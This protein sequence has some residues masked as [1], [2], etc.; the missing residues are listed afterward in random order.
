MFALIDI[1]KYLT[2]IS[3]FGIFISC[4]SGFIEINNNFDSCRLLVSCIVFIHIGA[5]L[6]VEYINKNKDEMKI[7]HFA[8]SYNLFMLSMLVIGLSN[9]GVGF[10]IYGL[11][12]SLTNLFAAVFECDYDTVHTVNDN[13]DNPVVS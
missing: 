9:V 1:V 7:I 6:F 8:R 11:T 3:Y 12:M 13:M 5:T 4:I 10:G 2:I